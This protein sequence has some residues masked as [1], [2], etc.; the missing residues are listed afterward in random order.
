VLRLPGKL[1][2]KHV[3]L[4]AASLVLLV[5][6]LGLSRSLAVCTKTCCGGHVQINPSWDGSAAAPKTCPCCRHDTRGERPAPADG[7]TAVRPGCA[8]CDFVGLGVEL[9]MPPGAAAPLPPAALAYGEPEE[10]TPLRTVEPLAVAH[11]PATGP[12]RC[13]RRTALLATTILRL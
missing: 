10:L 12:P 8:G 1:L 3:A 4:A 13:D 7:R 2:T 9:G 11:P 5:L 6:G